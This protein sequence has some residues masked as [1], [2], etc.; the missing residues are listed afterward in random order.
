MPNLQ[1]YTV[2]KHVVR[3]R[4]QEAMVDWVCLIKEIGQEGMK[5]VDVK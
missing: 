3:G 2:L 4:S 5:M 1:D